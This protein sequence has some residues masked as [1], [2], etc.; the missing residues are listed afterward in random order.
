MKFPLATV[1]RVRRIQKDVAQA[2]AAAAH[3]EV[4]RAVSEHARREAA[5]AG[6][7]EPGTAESAQWLAARAAALAMAGD[8]VMARQVTAARELDAADARDRLHLAAMAHK[9][10]EELAGRHAEQARHDREAAEQRAADDRVNA[11]YRPRGGPGAGED[12]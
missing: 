3:A 7:P 12:L 4:N 10:I 6:R 9:G 1:L 5:L 2:S 11:T 8:V